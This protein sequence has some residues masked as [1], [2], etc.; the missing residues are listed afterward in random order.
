MISGDPSVMNYIMILEE[1]NHDKFLE[2]QKNWLKN[3]NF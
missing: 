1:L 2:I 3:V